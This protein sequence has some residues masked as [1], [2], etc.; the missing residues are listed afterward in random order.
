[1]QSYHV[2][3]HHQG[4]PELDV[5]RAAVDGGHAAPPP[6]ERL[7]ARARQDRLPQDVRHRHLRHQG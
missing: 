7:A 4:P 2:K 1:M 6:L 5:L 3:N